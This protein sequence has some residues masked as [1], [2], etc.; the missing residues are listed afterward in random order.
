MTRSSLL[1]S[2]RFAA[3]SA[4]LLAVAVLT[5]TPPAWAED[6]SPA[7]RGQIALS[8]LYDSNVLRYSDKYL[9][10]FENREDE[11]RFHIGSA[12]DL[13]LHSAVHLER[14]FNPLGELSSVFSGDLHFWNYT[15]NSIKNWWTFTL[16]ARQE[17]PERFSLAAAYSHIPQFYV[18]HY[19]D[20]D[21]A[22]RVGQIPARFQPFSFTKDEFRIGVAQQLF[23]SSRLRVTYASQRYYYNQHYTEYDSRN[24]VWGIDAAHP[25][26]PTLRISFAYAYTTSEAAGADQPGEQRA[27]ADDANGSFKEDSYS[28]AVNWRLPRV[29]G[30]TT[31][32]SLDGEY[33]RRCFTSTHFY[34]LDPQ[35]AGRIDYEYQ[36]S[37][38]WSVRLAEDWEASI[39]YTWRMRDTRTSAPENQSF[40]SD[41]KN[42]REYQ[43]EL[44]VA[45]DFAF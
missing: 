19:S 23:Q 41:E 15:H 20:D 16:G 30:L 32:L 42:F 12:D 37:L 18:R 39:G 25:I 38:D 28:A 14:S 17:L 5:C 2:V 10:R 4:A 45:Y 43:V 3:R 33:S 34:A 22:A 21:W 7:W 9:G 1:P 11:G 24:E 40:L 29:A 27:F 26:L 36:A 35:H 13:L 6:E 44:G 31:R 8:S